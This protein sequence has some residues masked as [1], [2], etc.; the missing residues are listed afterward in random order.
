MEAITVTRPRTMLDLLLWR[1]FGADG[2]ALL[3]QTLE[4]NP[5]LAAAGAEIP[6]GTVVMLPDYAPKRSSQPVPVL[7]LFGEG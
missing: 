3:E 7:D 6:I 4:A 5:G 1:K 2:P